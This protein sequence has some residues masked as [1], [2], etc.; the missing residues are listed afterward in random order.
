ME[1]FQKLAGYSLGGADQVRRFMS[2]KKHDKLAHEREAFINGDPERGIA[3]CVANGISRE[4]ANTLF[5]QMTDFASYAFNKSHAAA[6]ALTS[7]HTAFLKLYYPAEFLMAAMNWAKHEEYAGL[8]GEA[9]SFHVAVKA[10]DI[11]KSG[12]FFTVDDDGAIRFGLSSIKDVGQAADD[13][14]KERAENG[15]FQSFRDVLERTMIKKDAL[16]AM[17]KAGCFDCF[18]RNRKALLAVCEPARAALKARQS[19]ELKL[20]ATEELVSQEQE[21]L[22]EALAA[23][24]NSLAKKISAAMAKSARQIKDQEKKLDEA[25]AAYEAALSIP[26][27]VREDAELRMKAEY[28]ALGAFVTASPLDEYPDPEHVG[29][30]PIGNTPDKGNT[31]LMGVAT[32][33]QLKHKKADGKPMLFLTLEDRTG[34][35][36]VQLFTEAYAS[37]GEGIEE[38]KVYTMRGRIEMDEDTK[39]FRPA[40]LSVPNR[41]I[42]P[43]IMTVPSFAL[44][45]TKEASGFKAK[46]EDAKG[47]ALYVSDQATGNMRELTYRVNGAVEELTNVTRK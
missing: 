22:T 12:K 29:A 14:L 11:N 32:N 24:D 7:Y 9:K 5:D 31:V 42:R 4:A 37:F 46:Y 23:E 17:V 36:D 41:R 8:I 44:W 15:A 38:G 30:V 28:E 40:S 43:Y 39:K 16:E 6:Y 45:H 25:E 34:S 13:L 3:G 2:K 18:H 19:A 10:P 35:I 26:S 47:A 20:S 21:E 33:L 1:I 27:G